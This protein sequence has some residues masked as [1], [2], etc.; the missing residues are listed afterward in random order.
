MRRATMAIAASV[1]S[2]LAIAAKPQGAGAKSEA[3]AARSYQLVT[4][5]AVQ[6]KDV[7]GMQGVQTAQLWGDLSKDGDWGALLKFKAGTDVGW[8]THTSRI[9]LVMVS[10]TLSIHPE[11]GSPTELRAGSYADDPGKVK[12]RTVCKEGE[13]CIFLLHMTKKFDFLAAKEPGAAAAGAAAP[14]SK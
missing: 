4:A 1:L 6:F 3:R 5:D 2:L 12:H 10:G 14:K 11:G 8:H 13:D 9:H 7:E